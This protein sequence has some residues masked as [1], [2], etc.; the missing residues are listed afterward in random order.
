MESRA[1]KFP[2]I[3]SSHCSLCQGCIEV[4]P[5]VFHLDENSRRI[6]IYDLREYPA[7]VE[8]AIK[9]CPRDCISWESYEV[10][11]VDGEFTEEEILGIG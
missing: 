4:E 2:V 10:Q 3:D 9:N 1:E 8:E 7:T 5:E 11:S 6:A